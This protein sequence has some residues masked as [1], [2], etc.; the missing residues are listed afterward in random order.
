MLD[1]D[2]DNHF[3]LARMIKEG[4]NNCRSGLLTFS[5]A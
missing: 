1:M 4:L 3:P 5:K 2:N